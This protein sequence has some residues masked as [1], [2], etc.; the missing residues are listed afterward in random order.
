[1][2]GTIEP[3]ESVTSE[4]RPLGTL[5]QRALLAGALLAVVYAAMVLVAAVRTPDLGF[6]VMW[7]RR[8][9]M[10]RPGGPAARAGLRK[11]DEL[12]GVGGVTCEPYECRLRLEA[13]RIGQEVLATVRRGDATLQA[14]YLPPHPFRIGAIAGVLL[15][16]A[17]LGI[18]LLADR[19]VASGAPRRFYFAAV[20]YVIVFAGAFSWDA[21]LINSYLCLLWGAA[22]L[23]LAPVSC[24]VALLFPGGPAEVS[25]RT[26]NLLYLPPLT[27]VIA[28]S[29]YITMWSVG[30]FPGH[31]RVEFVARA[32]AFYLTEVGTVIYL[33][34]GLVSRWRRRHTA[35]GI[36]PAAA[37]WSRLGS[38]AQAAAAVT[39][40]VAAVRDFDGFLA[41]GFVPY[42]AVGGV[43]GALCMMLALTRAPLGELDRVMRRGAG[44]LLATTFAGVLYFAVIA[45]SGGVAAP[46][47]GF[48]MT[49]GVT[50]AAAALFGPIRAQIQRIVDHRFGRQQARAQKL[51]AAA[52]DAAIRTLDPQTLMRDVVSRLHEATSVAGVAL[53]EEDD[54]GAMVQRASAGRVALGVRLLPRDPARDRLLTA[55]RGGGIEMGGEA[56]AFPIDVSRR[57]AVALVLQPSA[58]ARVDSELRHL[59]ETLAKQLAVALRNAHAHAELAAL[60][61]RMRRQA[62]LAERQRREI[63]RLKERIEEESRVLAAEL[64]R[65]GGTAPVIGAGLRGVYE[66]AQQV[67]TSDAT[68]LIEG[69]TGTGKD[70][71]AHAVHAW[72]GR[73]QKPFVV[74]DCGAIPNGLFESALFGHERGAFTGAQKRKI[75]LIEAA[76]GGTLFLDEIGELPLEMQP[77]LLGVIERRAIVR[78]GAEQP[79]QVDVRI[80]AATNRR[81]DD[82]VRAGNFRS[83]LLYRLRV[84]DLHIPPLRERTQDIPGLATAFMERH[85]RR[86]GI[87]AKTLSPEALALVLSYDW[88]GNVRELEHT[89]ERAAL[90]AEEEQIR[91]IELSVEQ[92][93]FRRRGKTRLKRAAVGGLRGTLEQLEAER[94]SETLRQYGGNRSQAARALGIK[95]STLLRR[96]KRYGL[97]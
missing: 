9:T 94:L 11:G 62:E 68:V 37:R 38:L 74:V 54:D 46:R 30:Y 6:T 28:F 27:A 20:V 76:D 57:R 12:I 5:S 96:L 51:V 34:S 39:G 72:S 48:G 83:D 93:L 80:V 67:A 4:M 75:G 21:L 65:Q 35:M 10:V 32:L 49:L 31:P 29:A 70:L 13:V 60:G 56:L 24:H 1:V 40:G 17:L 52:A 22:V 23:V 77:K 3:N 45:F 79:L 91:P 7:G 2:Q 86:L 69:E 58:G 25:R 88:P 19:G 33:V 85:A 71:L 81:L 89:L 50:L 63:Q 95:R 73:S 26:L 8:V 15:G 47:S 97:G 61:E 64:S 55:V 87:R 92:E 43:G 18:A 16:A 82:E 53:Y 59:V 44:Y 78:V 42:L 66:R 84:V 14:R 41:G 90:L 36:D